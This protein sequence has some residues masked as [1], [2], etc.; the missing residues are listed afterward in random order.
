M[1]SQLHQVV[2]YIYHVMKPVAYQWYLPFPH[3]DVHLIAQREYRIWID[4]PYMTEE[5][6][7]QAMKVW[8][9]QELY[10]ISCN[11]E[12]SVEYYSYRAHVHHLRCK[13]LVKNRRNVLSRTNDKRLWNS[14]VSNGVNGKRYLLHL[15]E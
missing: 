9:H 1:N 10:C 12:P 8:L 13:L 7:L 15:Q 6:L 11:R 5:L 14:E 4:S 2:Q 3:R